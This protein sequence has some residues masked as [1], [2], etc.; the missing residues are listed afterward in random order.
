MITTLRC[1]FTQCPA[2]IR[3]NS[4]FAFSTAL[5]DGLE[6]T[7]VSSISKPTVMGEFGNDV[8]SSA[9][10]IQ[11]PGD[12]LAPGT[13]GADAD[14]A[15]ALVAV[16]N[17]AAAKAAD[18][19]RRREVMGFM[20]AFDAC[21]GDVSSGV[22]RALRRLARVGTDHVGSLL[23]DHDG[24]GIGVAAAKRGHD[25]CVHHAQ[26]VNAA[27]AQTGIYYRVRVV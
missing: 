9:S 27:H 2:Y 1:A 8:S 5:K 22:R 14:C 26:S 12:T 15:N 20:M 25:R 3:R 23:A 10:V 18:S 17:R 7:S 4:C 24:R 6:N 21:L 19:R 11:R 16:G 13:G